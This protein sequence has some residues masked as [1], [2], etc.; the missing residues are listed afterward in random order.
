MP[1]WLPDLVITAPAIATLLFA[2]AVCGCWCRRGN[3]AA[4]TASRKLLSEQYTERSEQRS[5]AGVAFTTRGPDENHVSVDGKLRWCE[6]DKSVA[7]AW[8][9]HKFQLA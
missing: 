1:P 8:A 5:V 3:A 7:V 4:V 2:V 6:G 9:A